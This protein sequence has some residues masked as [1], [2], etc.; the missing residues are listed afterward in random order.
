MDRD[1][2]YNVRAL[3][4]WKSG[5]MAI[6]LSLRHILLP[7]MFLLITGN[8]PPKITVTEISLFAVSVAI[9]GTSRD[10]GYFFGDRSNSTLVTR[11]SDPVLVHVYGRTWDV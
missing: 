3:V 10:R 8:G 9:S 11:C 1:R 7:W 4:P 6:R 5:G 2:H